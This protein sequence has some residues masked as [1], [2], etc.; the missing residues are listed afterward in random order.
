LK[1]GEPEAK[2]ISNFRA[3]IPKPFNRAF[4]AQY[5]HGFA[6]RELKVFG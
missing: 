1:S 6:V 5:L 2:R 3:K 4:E